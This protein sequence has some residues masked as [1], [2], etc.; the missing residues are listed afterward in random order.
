MPC[1]KETKYVCKK[2]HVNSSINHQNERNIKMRRKIV[3]WAIEQTNS[4]FGMVAL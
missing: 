2:W 4:T 3:T 1:L